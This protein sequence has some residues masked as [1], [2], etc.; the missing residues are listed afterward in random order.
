VE[1]KF[2]ITKMFRLAVFV[3]FALATAQAP[4]KLK[5]HVIYESLCPD[6]QRFIAY[7]LLPNYEGLA[8]FIDIVLVPFGKSRSLPDETFTCQ[9]GAN[10]CRLNRIMSCGLARLPTQP[11][12]VSYVGCQMYY[13]SEKTGEACVTE[14][15]LS[16]PEVKFCHDS[17]LGYSLQI[18]HENEQNRVLG[19]PGFV[20][21]IVVNENYD[22]ALQNRLLNDFKNTICEL[23]GNQAETCQA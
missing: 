4:E 16:W 1:D 7:Q 14:A 10:E 22:S 18:A 5:V 3:L 20:P 15:G 17:R 21:T 2:K 9:H 8:D 6:S 23:I 13:D 19:Y 11:Q 12:Q